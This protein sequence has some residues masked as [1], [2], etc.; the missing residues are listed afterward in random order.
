MKW[1]VKCD[2]FFLYSTDLAATNTGYE[3][4]DPSLSLELNKAATFTFTIYPNHRNYEQIKRLHSRIAVYRDGVLIFYGRP[5]DDKLGWNNERTIF[6]E[7][8]LAFLNDSILRPF[9][10]PVVEGQSSVADY[11]TFLIGKH[12]AQVEESKRFKVGLI[13]VTD[14]NDYVA[15]SDTEYSTTWT[16]LNALIGTHGGYIVP[17]YEADGCYLDYLADFAYRSNQPIQLGL[18]LLDLATTRKGAD[19]ITALIPLGGAPYVDGEQLPRIN[20]SALPNEDTGDIRKQDDYVY[21]VSAVEQYGMISAVNIWDDVYENTNLLRKAK[22]LLAEKILIPSTV[23]IS[24][25]DLAGA[26]YDVNAFEIGRYVQFRDEQHAELHGLD[27]EY[28]VKH[29]DIKLFAPGQNKITVGSTTL[30]FT[31]NNQVRQAAER[32]EIVIATM[33]ATDARVKEVR[34]EVSSALEQTEESIL[35]EVSET[36]L[37]KDEGEVLSEA[38]AEV[39]VEAGQILTTVAQ[40]YVSN[41]TFNGTV[42]NLQSQIDDAIETYSGSAV[43]TLENYP[44]SSW[45]ADERLKHVGDLY[46]VNGDGGGY[47]GFYYRFERVGN[48]FRWTL[49]KDSEITKALSDAADAQAAADAAQ[50]AADLAQSDANAAQL[51]ADAAAQAAADAETHAAADASAKAATAQAAAEQAAALQSAADAAAAEAAAKQAAAVDATNKA[52]AALAAAIADT[53]NKLA[54]YSTTVQMNSAIDQKADS[55]TSTVAA[56]YATQVQAQGYASSAESA[57]NAA[58]DAKLADYSTTTQME[59]AINQTADSITSTVTGQIQQSREIDLLPNS[60]FASNTISVWNVQDTDYAY[61]DTVD[62]ETALV[63]DG[64]HLSAFDNWRFAYIELDAHLTEPSSLPWRLH[65]TYRPDTDIANLTSQRFLGL[66][67]RVATGQYKGNY[68]YNGS[69]ISGSASSDTARTWDFANFVKSYDT[70]RC[71]AVFY[72]IPGIKYYVWNARF[73]VINN[74]Y[75]KRSSSYIE[76]KADSIRLKAD[77]IVW[78]AQNSSMNDQGILTCSGA[79]ISGDLEMIRQDRTVRI[80]SVTAHIV[81]QSTGALDSVSGYGLKAAYRNSNHAIV[82]MYD[83]I[84]EEVVGENSAHKTYVVGNPAK[85]HAFSF[86]PTYFQYAFYYDTSQSSPKVM[87]FSITGDEFNIQRY[88]VGGGNVDFSF[89]MDSTWLNAYNN[90]SSGN[91]LYKLFLNSNGNRIDIVAGSVELHVYNRNLWAT[92]SGTEKYVAFQSSSSLR[93]KHDIAPLHQEELDPHRLLDLQPKQFVYNE[94]AP[95]QYND[96]EGQLL[97]GFIAE[98]VAEVYP[99]AVIHDHDGNIESWDERRIIPGMLALIQEQQKEIEELKFMVQSLMGVVH[100]TDNT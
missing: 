92:F 36:Y 94:N 7:G 65:F 59:T 47:A 78:D 9:S 39:E 86:Y 2:D 66:Y 4:F 75:T 30:S 17:R 20:I 48:T 70:D 23:A 88:P 100:G 16:I 54:N 52:D 11:F 68:S 51:S 32:R 77:I 62:D 46:I 33:T 12:N 10:F 73:Y 14:A 34:R 26:G 82:P 96:M 98:D 67:G 56:T 53:N 25:A 74:D 97:P 90:D 15:R 55:I 24:A 5:F 99:A 83:Y 40:N 45:T 35:A 29:L 22:Q 93:Y 95:L 27:V 19:I 72:F 3:I 44:A 18:N 79:N 6:C 42:S 43:P 91:T 87:G 49:L 63:I 57:A 28:L 38:I 50:A 80:A 8:E 61:W 89:M 69:T 31:E 41:T 58:T 21:S 71:L 13:T 64:T 1:I 76:Q 37:T 60:T 85:Y 81:N 84:V